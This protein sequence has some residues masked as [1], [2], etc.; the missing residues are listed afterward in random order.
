MLT[1]CKFEKK[2]RH[3]CGRRRCKLAKASE[4]LCNLPEPKNCPIAQFKKKVKLGM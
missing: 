2:E 1:I 4:L 3:E